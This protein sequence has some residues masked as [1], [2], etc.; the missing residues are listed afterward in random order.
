[1][2]PNIKICTEGNRRCM[3]IK[4]KL[5][6][7]SLQTLLISYPGYCVLHPAHSQN[8]DSCNSSITSD[9]Y[10]VTLKP[11]RTIISFS[12]KIDPL[13]ASCFVTELRR[14]NFYVIS[15][16][17]TFSTVL[18]R[19]RVGV[20]PLQ[21]S[22]KLH[23]VIQLQSKSNLFAMEPDIRWSNRI[24]PLW[25]NR[26]ILE[27]VFSWLST[28]GGAYSSLGDYETRFAVQAG[29]LSV[30]QLKLAWTLGDPFLQARCMVYLAQSLMQR[31]FFKLSRKLIRKQYK[32]AISTKERDHR[33]IAM[34]EGVWTRI[35]YSQWKYL[36]DRGHHV[37]F[38]VKQL[39]AD[40]EGK[41]IEHSNGCKKIPPAVESSCE[42]ISL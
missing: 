3:L 10:S 25:T 12:D 4:V 36:T 5:N 30:K 29:R 7:E 24:L 41:S 16:F 23:V 13:L 31:G 19:L 34:C 8:N 39:R 6:S 22:A 1:M 33:L 32:F 26:L 28:L 9:P 40:K 37:E 38:K 18:K 42:I 27:D 15:C 14:S 11:R 2:D 17:R 21:C 20:S 35:Y